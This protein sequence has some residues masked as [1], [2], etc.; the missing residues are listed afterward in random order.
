MDQILQTLKDIQLDLSKQKQDMKEMENNITESINNNI[1]SKFKHIEEK[2]KNLELKIDQQQ[3]T[4][5]ILDKQLRRKNVIF[6]GVEE[7]EKGYENLLSIILEILNKNM[8]ISC[9]QWEIENV[10]RMG[11][12]TGKIRPVAVTITTMSRRIEILKNKKSLENTRIYLKE[13]FSPAIL[14]KRKELQETLKKERESGKRVALHYDK[15]IELKP[16]SSGPRT[17]TERN[18]N[19]RILSISPEESE[20]NHRGDNNETTKQAPSTSNMNKIPK[21]NKRNIE[22][23]VIREPKSTNANSTLDK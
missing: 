12:N 11:K 20:K 7:K 9:K 10:I 13:D 5:D 22:S 17:P 3:K 2:T 19:K 6:F 18:T 16:R 21:R 23:F 8:N 14:Q 4:I 15:I 1:D